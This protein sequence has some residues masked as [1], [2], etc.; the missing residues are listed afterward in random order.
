MEKQGS[1]ETH[2]GS[3]LAESSEDTGDGKIFFDGRAASISVRPKSKARPRMSKSGHVYTPKD[4]VQYEKLIADEW[5]AQNPH[6]PFSNPVS[7][8]MIFCFK[9]PKSHYNSKGVLKTDVP[10]FYTNTPDID[11][12]EKSILDGLNGV[13]YVDDKL[14]WQKTGYKMWGDNDGVHIYIR[15]NKEKP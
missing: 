10:K 3:L 9:R 11:N 13:A 1:N 15:E 7:V 2:V 12:I 14:I 6:P 5:T 8:R 4:T